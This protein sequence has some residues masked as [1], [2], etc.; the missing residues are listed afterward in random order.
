MITSI[1][2]DI[3]ETERLRKDIEKFGERFVRRILGPLEMTEFQALPNKAAFLAGQFA[4]KEAVV[5]ALVHYLEDRPPLN[6]IQVL[7]DESGLLLH[8]PS[9]ITARLNNARCLISI[10]HTECHSTAIAIFTE[11]K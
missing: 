4:A 10:S 8:L 1:G 9:D 3:A 7:P 6:I 11:E 5:K 2:I